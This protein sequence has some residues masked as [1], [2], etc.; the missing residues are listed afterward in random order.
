MSKPKRLE[1]GARHAEVVQSAIQHWLDTQLLSESEATQLA[2][3]ITIRTFDWEKFAK[4]TLR[5]AII[6]LVIAVSSVVLEAS[7]IRLYR[8]IVALPAWLRGAITALMAVAVHVF[9]YDR[10][11]KMPRQ[12]Y[13]NEG[14]HAV[15]ALLFALAAL[16]VI[17]QLNESYQQRVKSQGSD[18]QSEAEKE[19]EEAARQRRIKEDRERSR[20]IGNAIWAV[21]LGLAAVYATV[22]LL[23]KSTLIWTCAIM[24]TSSCIGG[25]GGYL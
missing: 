6:C 11:V 7:F 22:A 2:D 16:Q 5:L 8:R 12:K 4:Y 19:D 9:A 20:L 3:S 1:L 21:S 18:G 15:G 25:S 10:S 24:V 14:I 13:A 17:E 23:S